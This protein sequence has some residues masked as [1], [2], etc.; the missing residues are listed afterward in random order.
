MLRQELEVWLDGAQEH[1]RYLHPV[2]A[3]EK[4]VKQ[5]IFLCDRR[6]SGFQ[7]GYIFL[8]FLCRYVHPI[9]IATVSDKLTV[10]SITLYVSVS[11]FLVLSMYRP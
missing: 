6:R 5:S 8:F 11:L 7:L 3:K 10:V 9:H 1:L 2:P 4:T